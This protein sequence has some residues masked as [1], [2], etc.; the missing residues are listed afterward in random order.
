[1]SEADDL[2][3]ILAQRHIL[4]AVATGGRPPAA[5]ARLTIRLKTGV[6]QH[7]WVAVAIC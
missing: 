7:I 5:C 3:E 1:M 2:L 6:H 4:V